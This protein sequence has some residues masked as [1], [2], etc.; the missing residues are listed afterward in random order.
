M[1]CGDTNEL[2]KDFTVGCRAADQVLNIAQTGQQRLEGAAEADP[3]TDAKQGFG[4]GIEI[5]ECAIRID[6]QDRRCQ[7]AKDIGRYGRTGTGLGSALWRTKNLLVGLVIRVLPSS[8]ST[9]TRSECSPR[10][11]SRY[12]VCV[13]PASACAIRPSR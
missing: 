1:S 4:T 8:S 7:A 3:G 2:A 12:C 10:N 9:S 6:D 5:D 11:T 13:R